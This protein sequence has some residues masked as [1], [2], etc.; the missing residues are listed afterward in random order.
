MPLALTVLW[1]LPLA[2]A[3]LGMAQLWREA[4]AE[5]QRQIAADNAA[6]VLGQTVRGAL[7]ALRRAEDALEALDRGHHALHACAAVKPTC[8]AADLAVE[9]TIVLLHRAAERAFR[10]AV[11]GASAAAAL[12]LRAAPSSQIE[13]PS[14][15]LA[16]ASCRLCRLPVHWRVQLGDAGVRGPAPRRERRIV[17]WREGRSEWNYRVVWNEVAAASWSK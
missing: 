16:S 9:R 1:L 5:E 17:R 6:I 4:L 8:R 12:E 2:V 13:P 3:P 10:A 15:A 7:R 14:V 11:V